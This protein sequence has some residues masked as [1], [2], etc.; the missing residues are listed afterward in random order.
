MIEIKEIPYE[1]ARRA[2]LNISFKPEERAK[3]AMESF[4]EEMENILKKIKSE[5]LE[6]Y[7]ELIQYYFDKKYNLYIDWL[8]KMSRCFSVMITG[9]AKF[10]NRAHEKANKS[11]HKALEE[12]VNYNILKR[13]EK[14]IKYIKKR[15]EI[16][17][18]EEDSVIIL[19][20]DDFELINNKKEERVQFL[21]QDK[22]SEEIR[23]LLKNNAFRWSPS[24]GAW[25]RKNTIN[26]LSVAKNIVKKLGVDYE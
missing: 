24:K 11:E 8:Y 23:T 15:E 21:F 17:S 13:L 20:N 22:P 1:T 16:E 10:N 5:W 9:P 3:Q 19:K 4:A 26:G 7:E 14:K 18:R 2:W 25:Q 6:N 12:Y